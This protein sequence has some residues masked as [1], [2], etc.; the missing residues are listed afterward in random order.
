MEP[1]VTIA[2]QA[3][4]LAHLILFFL[5]LGAGVIAWMQISG[6]QLKTERLSLELERAT[7]E[8]EA[9]RQRVLTLEATL[10]EAEIA[11]AEARARSA[12]DERKFAEMAQ[13]VLQRANSQFLQLANE[14]FEKH[15]EGAQGQLRELMKPIGEN[16]ESFKKRVDEIE[17]VRTEDK[18]AIQEQVKAIHE[19]LLHHSKETGKLVN[20]LTAPKGGG[21]W[22]EMTLRNV[23]EQAGLS[24]HCDFAEQV[25]EQSDTGRQRPDAVINLPGGRQIVVDSKVSLESYMAAVNTEDPVQKATHLKAHAASVQRHVQTL[26]SKDY[27]SNLGGRFDYIAMFIPGENFFAAALE[28]SPDLIEK[29]MS[30]SVIVTTPTTLIALA[31][32]V[33]HLWRQHEMNENAMAAADLGAELYSRIGVMLG[34]VEKLGKS[35]NTSVDSYNSL[36]GSLDKRVMPTLKKFED[37]KIAPPNKAPAEPK[38]IESRANTAETGQLDLGD[39]KTLAAE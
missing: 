24:K 3:F 39:P 1:I 27:Q 15:K 26:A 23:M 35:L 19:S 21:R 2:G 5:A 10:R 37:M 18:S 29:A 4:D 13:G 7:D 11:L 16:F 25:S 38:L 17:K 20:A 28:Y 6:A 9:A 34:H 33:A 30:R 32:T 31:R 22:G 36:M 12:E 8:R 14:T